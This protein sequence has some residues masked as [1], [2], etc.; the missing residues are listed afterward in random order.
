MSK[1]RLRPGF[2]VTIDGPAGAGKSTVSRMLA[3]AIHGTLLDTGSMYRGVA[4]FAM[5]SGGDTEKD[6]TKIARE[7]R[8]DLELK[9]KKLK[10]NGKLLGL[11]LRGERVTQ[12]ASSVSRFPSVRKVLTERQ[13]ELGRVLSKK[14]PVVMEGRDIGSVVFPEAKFKF[15]VTADAMVRARRRYHELKAKG[16]ADIKLRRVLSEQKKRDLQDS[17][18]EQA[19]LTFPDNAVFVD[20]SKMDVK[21]VVA[22]MKTH[23]EQKLAWEKWRNQTRQRS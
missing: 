13:R 1:T 2:L 5:Q 9:K 3:E 12:M 14:L 16:V 23:I 4:Y 17:T 15:Y 18:R 20:T 11:K 22:F 7:L 21:Q 19:P 10:I 8:F 6:F